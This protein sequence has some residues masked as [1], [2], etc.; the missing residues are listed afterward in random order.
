M[1]RSFID[2]TYVPSDNSACLC[3][4]GNR[5]DRF[6]E[7]R[8]DDCVEL[9]IENENARVIGISRGRVLMVFDD[10]APRGLMRPSELSEFAPRMERAILL[11]Y[12][13]SAPRLAV[14]LGVDPDD[15]NLV[16]PDNV[17]LV[18]FR[19]LALQG[20]L[21]H[22]DLG[23]VA[24]G[25]ATLAWHSS[26]RFCGRCGSTT[27]MR[28]GGVKRVCASCCHEQFPRTDP[29]VI[30]LTISGDRCLLGRSP[31]FPPGMFSALA[32]FVEAGESLEMAVRRETFEESG[33]RVGNVT[34]HASQPWPFPHTMMIGCYG[35]ALDN[36]IDADIEELEECRWFTRDEILATMD[37]NGPKN[38][39]GS[40]ALFIPPKMAIANQLVTDWAMDKV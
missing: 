18:D 4:G 20:L 11:G 16:L 22:E 10:G 31:H 35:E 1:P 32:G 3:F 9:G 15:E 26:A 14:P 28:G 30:M 19:S 2:P 33:I 34:Y 40:P 38:E 12:D 5:L 21:G 24:Q 6:S 27:E 37:G 36:V 8:T 25:A 39:D 7:D 29:V 23:L 13:S 17:K